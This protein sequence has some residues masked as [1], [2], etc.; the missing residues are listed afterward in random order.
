MKQGYVTIYCNFLSWFY[1]LWKFKLLYCNITSL[2]FQIHLLRVSWIIKESKWLMLSSFKTAGVLPL[3]Y[4]SLMSLCPSLCKHVT[5]MCFHLFHKYSLTILC[6]FAD[7]FLAK[8]KPITDFFFRSVLRKANILIKN[9]GT[10][11]EGN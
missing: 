8:R 3:W 2:H 6:M 4:L 10:I 11:V 9:Y 1:L 7:I 5:L